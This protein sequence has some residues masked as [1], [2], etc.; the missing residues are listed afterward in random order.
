[1]ICKSVCSL[2]ISFPRARTGN[3]E[4]CLTNGYTEATSTQR[5]AR[6]TFH[7]RPPLRAPRRKHEGLAE[8]Q[9]CLQQDSKD[10][11]SFACWGLAPCRLT[12]VCP[13]KP[14]PMPHSPRGHAPIG[15][16]GTRLSRP[17]GLPKRI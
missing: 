3:A 4:S 11:H 16:C 5:R 6:P 12:A 14:S 13:Q 17:N 1:M 9:S 2:C 10:R 8:E 15:R 7:A